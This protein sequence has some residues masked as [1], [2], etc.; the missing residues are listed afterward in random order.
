MQNHL[1]QITITSEK[2]IATNKKYILRKLGSFKT[3]ETPNLMF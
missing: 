2:I 1:K 3:F